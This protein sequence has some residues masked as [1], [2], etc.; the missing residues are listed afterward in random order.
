VIGWWLGFKMDSTIIVLYHMKSV[1][2][3]HSISGG[4]DEQII[5]N[6]PQMCFVHKEYKTLEPRIAKNGPWSELYIV[7]RDRS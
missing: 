6:Y 5:I 3:K 1:L 2:L 7:F 4:N